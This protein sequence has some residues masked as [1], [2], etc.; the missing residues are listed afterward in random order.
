MTRLRR[1]YAGAGGG[2][3][4]RFIEMAHGV[5]QGGEYITDRWTIIP[6]HVGPSLA[7][8]PG[9]VCHRL[10]ADSGR[11]DGSVLALRHHPSHPRPALAVLLPA[12]PGGH[13][14]CAS[15]PLAAAPPL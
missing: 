8:V 14:H 10:A 5:R 9:A 3:S 15:I 1:S 6:A 13:R 2:C 11:L 4:A 7:P 12:D